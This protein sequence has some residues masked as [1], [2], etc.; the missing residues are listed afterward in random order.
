M[1]DGTGAPATGPVDIVVEKDRIVKVVNVGTPGIPINAINRPQLANKGKTREIDAHGKYLLPG[2]IDSHSHI[3][4]PNKNQKVSA[5]YIFKLWLG[6]GVTSV[7][8]VF[9]SDGE[10][11]LLALKELSEINAITAPRITAYPFFN[12]PADGKKVLPPINNA[13]SARERVKYLKSIG[14]DGIKFMGAPER[15]LWAAFDEA[16]N[17][18]LGQPCIMR[19]L[20]LHMQ[21]S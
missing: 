18:N 21:M 4:S 17:N 7:R 19:N 10:S 13:E 3:H 9:G 6:H 15:I 16:E 1:I 11:R 20:M 8:E 14:A 5:D 2:F 12:M